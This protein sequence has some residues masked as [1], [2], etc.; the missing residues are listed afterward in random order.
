MFDL[1][2][3]APAFRFVSDFSRMMI[4]D[5]KYDLAFPT[6]SKGVHRLHHFHYGIP[7]YG[8]SSGIE[9]LLNI[10]KIIQRERYR[11]DDTPYTF[12]KRAIQ[13]HTNTY[14][15][16]ADERES[17]ERIRRLS[18]YINSLNAEKVNSKERFE[19][20]YR[21]WMHNNGVPR[22][23]DVI[24]GGKIRLNSQKEKSSTATT[25]ATADPPIKPPLPPSP[26]T[27]IV[28]VKR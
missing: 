5:D 15:S 28:K 3:L 7:L 8:V 26:S 16:V 4:E 17:R 24:Y 11:L 12:L 20:Q 6:R 25:A 19:R 9:Q 23:R 10:L 22:D 18:D 21:I 14:D 27:K 13:I 1:S 2:L